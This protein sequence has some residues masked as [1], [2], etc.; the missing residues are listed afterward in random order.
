MKTLTVVVPSYN[1]EKYID[2]CLPTFITSGSIDD[3]EILLISDGSTDNTLEKIRYYEAIHPDSIRVIDKENGGHGSVINRGIKEAAGK[4]FKVIDGDDWVDSKAFDNLV[5]RLKR[6]DADLVLNPYILH[7]IVTQKDVVLGK[8]NIQN[9][10]VYKFDD[11]VNGLP[12][13]ALHAV[14]YRTEMLRNSGIHLQEKCF[15][16]DAEYYIYPVPHIET[17]AYLDEPVYVYRIGSPTQSVNP[18]NAIRNKDMLA[19]IV[20]NL[21]QFYN[22]L[23]TELSPQ[24]KKYI[25][26]QICHII[27]NN[28]GIYLKMPIGREAFE[29]IEKFDKSLKEKSIELYHSS[30]SIAVRALRLN[31]YPV[32]TIGCKMF[33]LKRE[34][35]GF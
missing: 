10:H 22:D 29:G 1:T 23:P 31:N 21:I 11:W 25:N 8:A 35:R 30:S 27:R 9:N 16:E 26:N 3:V 19:I 15:Y 28:Y 7:N 5:N 4:Y 14:T 18:K 20:D 17:M 24:K 32:Y 34:K 13:L 2:E 6:I 12:L 33:Q